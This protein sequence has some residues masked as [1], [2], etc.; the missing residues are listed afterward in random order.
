MKDILKLELKRVFIN[1]GFVVA[2]GIGLFIC[3]LHIVLFGIIFHVDRMNLDDIQFAP[4]GFSYL[5]DTATYS[6]LFGFLSLNT[7]DILLNTYSFILPLL[8]C[9]PFVRSYRLEQS[10]RYSNDLKTP[11]NKPL[12]WCARLFA[13]FLSA[14]VIAVIPLILDLFATVLL[15][16][17]VVLPNAVFHTL[18]QEFFDAWFEGFLSSQLP[19]FILRFALLAVLAGLLALLGTAVT[20]RTKKVSLGILASFATYTLFVFFWNLAGGVSIVWAAFLRPI[21]YDFSF[22]WLKPGA[23]VVLFA[24]LGAALA[25]GLFIYFFNAIRKSKLS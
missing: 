23:M 8:V 12:Q 3:L 25:V 9:L 11:T 13:I 15:L 1:R 4:P 19:S 10:G 2:L 20:Y 17:V 5:L 16:A 14:A 18:S 6:Y 24:V 22:Y 21:I 7:Y